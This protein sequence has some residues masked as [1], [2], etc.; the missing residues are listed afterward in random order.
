MIPLLIGAG[1]ALVTL[2]GCSGYHFQ[3]AHNPLLDLGIHRIYVPNFTNKSFRPGLE[4]YFTTAMVREI[5]QSKSFELVNSPK[6][7][8]ATLIGVVQ[9]ADDSAASPS[10]LTVGSRSISVASEYS[11]TVSCMITLTDRQGRQVFNQA[12]FGNKAHPGAG[13]MGDFGATAPLTNDSSQRLAVQFLA[14]EMMA[15][16]YQRMVDTF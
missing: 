9:S 5:A 10:T 7:A 11:A 15:S 14:D 12:V 13:T 16:V 1:A 3:E 4:Q 8:D 6:E 2:A